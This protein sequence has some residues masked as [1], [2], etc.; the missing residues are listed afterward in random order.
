M[1]QVFLKYHFMG[2]ARACTPKCWPFWKVRVPARRRGNL[3]SPLRGRGP[4]PR[5]VQE[6]AHIGFRATA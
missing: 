3:M 1:H 2:F 6:K 4:A 5:K